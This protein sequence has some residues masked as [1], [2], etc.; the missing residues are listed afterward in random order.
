MAKL[1]FVTKLTMTKS[2]INCTWPYTY[3]VRHHPSSANQSAQ[4]E[5]KT[6]QESLYYNTTVQTT[7]T[8]PNIKTLHSLINQSFNKLLIMYFSARLW[9]SLLNLFV[10][11]ACWADFT[12]FGSQLRIRSERSRDQMF[13]PPSRNRPSSSTTH[14][15]RSPT[16]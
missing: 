15:I 16:L 4:G 9:S 5:K 7:H 1:R 2:R 11:L 6:E 13:P 12:T 3:V 8:N 14:G 10:L